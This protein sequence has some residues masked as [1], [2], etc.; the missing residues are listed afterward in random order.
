[1]FVSVKAHLLVEG[2]FENNSAQHNYIMDIHRSSVESLSSAANHNDFTPLYQGHSGGSGF[3]AEIDDDCQTA[4]IGGG[5]SGPPLER[6]EIA[7]AGGSGSW[8]QSHRQRMPAT[9]PVSGMLCGMLSASHIG[10][11]AHDSSPD[12][13]STPMPEPNAEFFSLAMDAPTP[14]PEAFVGN[15]ALGSTYT[16]TQNVNLSVD[17]SQNRLYQKRMDRRRRHAAAMA[18]N[19]RSQIMQ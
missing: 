5:P 13:P 15:Y 14:T 16:D 11:Q 3:G 1:M 12:T 4:I 8:G 9:T 17:L 10:N 19:Q 7:P 6:F 18:S 2:A